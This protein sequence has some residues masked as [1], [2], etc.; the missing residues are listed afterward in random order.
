MSDYN[1]LQINYSIKA[2]VFQE[3]KANIY[4]LAPD[5]LLNPNTG[6]KT[7]DDL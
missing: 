4:I 5:L 3:E 7:E 6:C 1:P 2:H